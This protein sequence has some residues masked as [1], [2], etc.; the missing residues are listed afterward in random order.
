MAAASAAVTNTQYTRCRCH[1]SFSDC[2]LLVLLR[3]FIVRMRFLRDAYNGAVNK[4]ALRG[5]VWFASYYRLF[6]LASLQASKRCFSCSSA[7]A[8]R[9]NAGHNC[10]RHTWSSAENSHHRYFLKLSGGSKRNMP[11]STG[12]VRPPPLPAR[13]RM[14]SFC[15]AKCTDMPH[16]FTRTCRL[17]PPCSFP[18]QQPA[19][20][21]LKSPRFRNRLSK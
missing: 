9:T 12:I 1:G 15:S 7:P 8:I 5:I 14:E 13:E 3:I 21:R 17:N 20:L 16:A 18:G 4:H 6:I 11:P 10:D 2:T 19:H